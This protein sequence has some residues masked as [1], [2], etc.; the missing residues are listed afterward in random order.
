MSVPVLVMVLLAAGA[1]APPAKS[2]IVVTGHAWAPFISPMGEPFRA[3]TADDDTLVRWFDQADRNRD[4]ILTIDE[5]QADASRFFAMLDTDHDGEIDPDELAEYEWEVAPD[6]QVMSRTRPPPGQG[7]AKARSDGKTGHEPGHWRSGSGEEDE[8]G[9]HYPHG[10]QGAARYA[11]LNLPEPVA[12]ADTNFDRSISL[13][14]FRQAAAQRFQILDGDQAG[15]LSLPQLQSRRL[16]LAQSKSK[17]DDPDER[18][19]S[20]LPPGN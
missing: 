5:M 20:P 10:L 1:P 12:A 16:T 18:L 8:M 14:E 2:P 13:A 9:S 17:K 19:G 11:I 4:G 7:P 6:I 15:R 3:S